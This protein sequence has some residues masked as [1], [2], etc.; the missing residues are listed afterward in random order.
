MNEITVFY[1]E[2][3]DPEQHQP[4]PDVK[5]L[6]IQEALVKQGKVNR[7]LYDLIGEDWQWYDKQSWS[8]ERWTDY[9]TAD[10]LRTWI[11]CSEGSIAG[12]FELQQKQIGE[13]ELAYFGL[14]PAFVGRG[15]GGYL[16]SQAICAAWAWGNTHRVIVNTCTLD[17]PG[18]LANY[19]ARGFQIYDE[20]TQSLPDG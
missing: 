20:K 7:F 15:F 16:L 12:Y 3:T 19:K 11:A 14:A 13:T 8:I 10:D 4:K 17:H 2:M 18:A 6:V 5:G 9:A 1:L